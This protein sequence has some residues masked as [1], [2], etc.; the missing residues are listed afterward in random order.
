MS[1]DS[2]DLPLPDDREQL[3][4]HNRDLAEL[5]TRGD[6]EAHKI[7]LATNRLYYDRSLK[8]L[9]H[10][11][12]DN[13]DMQDLVVWHWPFLLRKQPRMPIDWWQCAFI[14]DILAGRHTMHQETF[15][16]GCTKAGKGFSAAISANLWWQ[17]CWDMHNP[18]SLGTSCKIIVTSNTA[19]H[20]KKVMMGEIIRL[21]KAMRYTAPGRTLGDQIIASEEKYAK[22]ANP[23]KGESFSG[24]HSEATLF[25]FDEATGILAEYWALAETQAAMQVALANPRRS[26][27]WFRAAYPAVEPDESRIEQEMPNGAGIR[28]FHTIAGSDCI[29]VQSGEEIIPGQIDA[30]RFARIMAKGGRGAQ[31]FGLG[32]FPQEGTE[33]VII[34]SGWIPRH[35]A[36]FSTDHPI[37]SFGLDVSASLDGDQSV[38]TPC[39]AAGLGKQF[40]LQEVDTM[41]V[42]AWVIRTA[43]ST[44]GIDL[45]RQQNPIAV[46]MDGLG[47]GVGD[48]LR[49]LGCWVEEFRGNAT[50]DVD[51]RTF[52]NLRAEAYGMLGVRLNPKGP[53]GDDTF[54]LPDDMELHEELVAPK[55]L[56]DSDGVRWKCTPKRPSSA[57]DKRETVV[58]L[59][60]RSP[61]KGDSA[62][63][64]YHAYRKFL[65]YSEMYEV[66]DILATGSD[67]DENKPMTEQD[68]KELEEFDPHLADLV[69]GVQEDNRNRQ[70]EDDPFDINEDW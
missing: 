50:S 27:G 67:P 24:Q 12:G 58:G 3:L 70:F 7:Y 59:I 28:C 57:E 34:A 48:R 39:G 21:R 16:K 66:T 29:N 33:D 65:L 4:E 40:V 32:R 15:I 25:I 19:D 61:D 9:A 5:I 2:N 22:V 13:Q 56:F 17:S 42:V 63:Y 1:Q 37:V 54:G 38:L 53:S 51:S 18:D 55:K 46:D 64:A 43:N 6:Q 68:I 60:G 69:R 36:A 35:V 62:V 49:E 10:G 31:V 26:F 14:R 11:E 45:R 30:A 41:A 52:A 47:K 8:R 20:A 23:L 44:Y